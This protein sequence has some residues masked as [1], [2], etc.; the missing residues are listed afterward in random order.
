MKKLIVMVALL[1]VSAGALAADISSPSRGVVCDKKAGFCVDNQ[2][3]AMGLTEMYLGKAAQDKLQTTLG[4]GAGVSLSEYTFSNG[5]HCDSK[6]R[7]CYKDRYY[8]RTPDKRES[9]MTKQIFGHK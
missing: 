1:G 7:Q 8:P 6:E 2:G 4:D 9:K 3:I 5:V